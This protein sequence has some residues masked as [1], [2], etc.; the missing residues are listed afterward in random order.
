MQRTHTPRMPLGMR[1]AIGLFVLGMAGLMVGHA[2]AEDAAAKTREQPLVAVLR[3]ETPEADKALAFKGLAVVGSPACVAD[4]ATYLGNERLASWARITLEAIPGEEASAALRNATQTLSGRLLVGAI[5]S[6]GVRRDA[7]A[8]TVLETRLGDADADVAAAAAAAL[9]KIG[10]PEAA[11]VL[12][13]AVAAGPPDPETVAE[14]CVVCGERLLADGD[15][16]AALALFD[17]VR[18]SAVSEQRR[19]E[20]TRAAILA[21]GRDGIPLLIALLRSPSRRPFTMG[22][23]TARELAA[24]PNRDAALA[25]EVDLALLGTLVG[26]DGGSGEPALGSERMSLVI[27]LLA[28]RN[29]QGAGKAVQQALLEAASG[30]ETAVAKTAIRALGR[31]G[32]AASAARLLEIAAAGDPG[33]LAA[34]REA[35]AAMRAEGID[36]LIMARLADTDASGLPLAVQLTGDRRILTASGKVLPLLDHGDAAVRAAALA[37]LGSI[38]DPANLGAVARKAALPRDD[39]EGRLAAAALK[40][41]AVRMADR[42]AC[43][44]TLCESFQASDARRSVLI[45]TLADVGGSAA[46]AA[47]AAAAESGDAPLQDAATRVLGKWMTADAAPVLLDLATSDAAGPYRGRAL[48]GY[49]RIARQFALPEAERAAMC[50]KAMAAT[51]DPADQKAIIEILMR[52]P[53]ATTLAV[54][55]EATSLPDMTDEANAAV[56]AIEAKLATPA[57]TK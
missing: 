45:E 7:A 31:C 16:S 51:D 11:T 57:G 9:G 10:S 3:S 32:D 43:T 33:I 5:N 24:G 19:A 13:R 50:R 6:L 56:T 39:A 34:V 17:A 40:E 29:P 21:R 48:K 12:M 42:D 49:L 54:A 8:R 53:H 14:A 37:A 47:V 41:A 35:I 30:S 52:Y 46:L 4:V 18:K 27:D 55:R 25:Y 26:T 22:L 36:E 15:R 38:V 2:P 1:L 20:A 44:A 28:D 23:G